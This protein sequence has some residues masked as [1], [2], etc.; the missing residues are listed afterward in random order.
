MR[1]KK[2]QYTY[3]Y[4]IISEIFLH[5]SLS[6]GISHSKWAISLPNRTFYALSSKSPQIN[7]LTG[8]VESW[9]SSREESERWINKHPDTTGS[10]GLRPMGARHQYQ[11]L[12]WAYPV[13]TGPSP[14]P[15]NLPGG[16]AAVR[17]TLYGLFSNKEAR[18]CGFDSW[19]S[20]GDFGLSNR[21][22]SSVK[23]G[24]LHEFSF[25]Q[26]GLDTF[27]IMILT[28]QHYWQHNWASERVVYYIHTK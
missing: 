20:E 18:R 1:I 3:I 26:A 17:Q 23:S 9:H 19:T 5:Y 12:R 11:E 7:N 14:D 6:W 10:N 27:P 28:S 8:F 16:N 22:Y 25:L 15:W 4:F 21:G 2:L 13:G 24:E